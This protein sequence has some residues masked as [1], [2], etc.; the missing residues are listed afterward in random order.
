M[1]AFRLF[2]IPQGTNPSAL[3]DATQV[4]SRRDIFGNTETEDSEH[5][6]PIAYKAD[7]VV[8]LNETLKNTL[9]ADISAIQ[10]EAL[11]V[12]KVD[13]DNDKPP[14]IFGQ[15]CFFIL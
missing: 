7:L 4:V 12:Q 9:E 6:L 10:I 5:D 8:E 15:F 14:D 13:V 1:L 3:L 11:N 2:M